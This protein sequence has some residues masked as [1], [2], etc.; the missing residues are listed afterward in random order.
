MIM[1]MFT[2]HYGFPCNSLYRMNASHKQILNERNGEVCIYGRNLQ[3][4][5]FE[6]VRVK[7]VIVCFLGLVGE[8]LF[9]KSCDDISDNR[10][11]FRGHSTVLL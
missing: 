1:I 3:C 2:V 7:A 4:L 6:T 9:I 5:C 11:L 8:R 10:N